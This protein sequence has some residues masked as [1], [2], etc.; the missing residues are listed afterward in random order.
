MKQSELKE[1]KMKFMTLWKM[2]MHK[3]KQSIKLYFTYD[4]VF[5]CASCEAKHKPQPLR[6]RIHNKNVCNYASLRLNA[7]DK[8]LNWKSDRVGKKKLL[9]LKRLKQSRVNLR[10]SVCT[11]NRL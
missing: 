2:L 8:K 7:F 9:V 5:K 4:P 6:N 10:T 1:K 11:T 3:E